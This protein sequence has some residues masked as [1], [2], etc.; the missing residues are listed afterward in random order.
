MEKFLEQLLSSDLL[1]EDSK[2]ELRESFQQI[3]EKAQDEARQEARDE[4]SEQYEKD[5]TRLINAV[6]RMVRESITDHLVEFKEDVALLQKKKA[7]AAKAIAEADQRAARKV[8]EALDVIKRENKSVIRNEIGELVEDFKLQ[9]QQHVKLM[10]E[11]RA[12]LAE[13]REE[14]IGKMANVLEHLT[15]KEL[16]GIMEEYKND[17]RK[18]RENNFGRKMFEAFVAEFETSYFSRDKVLDALKKKVSESEAKRSKLEESAKKKIRE[19]KESAARETAKRT[20]LEESVKREKKIARLT[21]TLSGS[22][23]T[24][25]K[26]LLEGVSVDRMDKVFESYLDIVTRDN[27][28]TGRKTL[29]EGRKTSSNSFRTG[30]RPVVTESEDEVDQD[31]LDLQRRSGIRRA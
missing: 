12:K 26:E 17:I 3:L 2:N 8:A 15:K 20:R 11:G 10:K 22:A 13:E 19:L 24:Q 6:D 18:A 16:K 1:T 23:K 27:K 25:M 7:K 28:K 29:N 31:I 5:K 30:N 21:N 4:L 14:L 9:R